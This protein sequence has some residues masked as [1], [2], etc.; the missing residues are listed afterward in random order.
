MHVKE[1]YWISF[2]DELHIREWTIIRI[3]LINM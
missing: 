2:I 1:S 3:D